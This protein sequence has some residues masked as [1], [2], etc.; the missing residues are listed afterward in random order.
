MDRETWI[1][2]N[3]AVMIV[4][5]R[6]DRPR[7]RFS[8]PDRLI[9]QMWLWAVMHD[10]PLCWACRRSSYNSLLRPRCLPS[11]SQ[12]CKRL[13][14]ERI[15]SVRRR[16][17]ELLVG[18]SRDDLLSFID[19]KALVLNDY[20]TDPDARNGIASGKMHFGYKLHARVTD[21]GFIAEYTVLALNEGE[22][23]TARTLL[24]ELPR[25]AVVLAD[26]NYDSRFLYADV[27]EHGGWLLTRLK[28]RSRQPKNLKR[29]GEGRRAALDAWRNNPELCERVLHLR[30]AVER[31]FGHL[32]SF[33]GGLGPLPA[34]VRRLAR[35]RLWVD[36]K[37][38]VYHARL[39]A[40]LL[41]FAA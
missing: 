35:V 12:F 13:K 39:T 10:R 32:T 19:G 14:S 34:W 27:R 21:R 31:R 9:L 37:I 23:N 22:P 24:E 3:S 17:H 40:R 8:Y 5:R 7:R 38:A 26:A 11:I 28:G 6:L 33:G 16:L 36:A 25:G 20:S 15:A 18:Q 4:T 30:D 41:A 29:M 1:V 2:L